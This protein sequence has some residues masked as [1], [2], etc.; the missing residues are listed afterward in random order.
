MLGVIVDSEYHVEDPDHQEEEEEEDDRMTGGWEGGGE[1]GGMYSISFFFLFT[2]VASV[3]NSLHPTRVIFAWNM[4]RWM[5]WHGKDLMN[6]WMNERMNEW[7]NERMNEWT[8]K[9]RM[10]DWTNEWMNHGPELFDDVM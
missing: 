6:E 7:T 10:N 8:N 5:V 1:G 2:E 9:L 4:D 3:V